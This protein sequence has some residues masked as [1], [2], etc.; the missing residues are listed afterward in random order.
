M[1]GNAEFSRE[2]RRIATP[3]SKATVRPMLL[4]RANSTVA[5]REDSTQAPSDVATCRHIGLTFTP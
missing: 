1:T 2:A 3:V 4:R 5:D